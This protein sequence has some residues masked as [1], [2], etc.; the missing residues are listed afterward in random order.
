MKVDFAT[1]AQL[2]EHLTCNENVAR[3]DRGRWL[4]RDDV[5]EIKEEWLQTI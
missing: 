2:A 3:S 5:R 4:Q 1:L